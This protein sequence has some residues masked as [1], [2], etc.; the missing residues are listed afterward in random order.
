MCGTCSGNSNFAPFVIRVISSYT[1]TVRFLPKLG[2]KGGATALFN[3]RVIKAARPHARSVPFVSSLGIH[4]AQTSPVDTYR[5]T[6]LL[7]AAISRLPAN[8]PITTLETSFFNTVLL[9]AGSPLI[10]W[11]YRCSVPD[12]RSSSCESK[13]FNRNSASDAAKPK[14]RIQRRSLLCFQRILLD[15]KPRGEAPRPPGP[16]RPFH[17]SQPVRAREPRTTVAQGA[18]RRAGLCC[19]WNEWCF[20]GTGD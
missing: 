11:Y 15:S 3:P 19:T 18:Q 13:M 12:P 5:D 10:E 16:I 2:F 4:R 14:R 8:R 1:C 17:H 6:L 20:R 9:F 7:Y